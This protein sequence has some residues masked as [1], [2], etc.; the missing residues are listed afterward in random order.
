VLLDA[1]ARLRDE[2][3][4]FRC[5]L[6]GDGP[7]RPRIE[8]RVRTMRL[9]RAVKL[10]GSLEPDRVAEMYQT[11]DVIVLASFS[12]GVPVVLMEAMAYGRPVVATRVGGVPELVQDGQHGLVVPPGDAEALACALRRVL[13]DPEWAVSLG[14]NGSQYVR[15][16]FNV[17]TSACRLMDLFGL[18]HR[19]RVTGRAPV[20]SEPT[21]CPP[22]ATPQDS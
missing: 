21:P 6:V 16:Q 8:A 19:S 10:A 22:R 7:L 14:R 9:G 11:A 20:E 15:D 1:L 18:V 13:D 2:G 17:D 4:E 3:I 12:E 5:T